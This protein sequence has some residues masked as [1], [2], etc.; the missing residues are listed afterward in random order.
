[1]GNSLKAL[2]F[3]IIGAKG[4]NWAQGTRGGVDKS[5]IDITT[6]GSKITN[7]LFFAGE[8]LDYLGPCGGYNL[9]NAWYTGIVAGR[10]IIKGI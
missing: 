2:E 1:M 5:Q 3:Q 7:G 10:N 4:W 6:M 8:V 9:N